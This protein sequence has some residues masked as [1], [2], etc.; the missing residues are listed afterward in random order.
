MPASMPATE[1]PTVAAM[2]WRGACR[3]CPWCGDGRAYF[4][5]WFAKQE[6]C[7]KC[8]LSW[9]RDD[10]GFELGAATVNT[11]VTFGLVIVALAVSVGVT[12]PDVPVPTILIGLLV[13]ALVVPVIVYPVSYTLWQA[14]DLAMRAP[15]DADLGS[16]APPANS[17][18]D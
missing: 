8:G 3:R 13:T 1:G 18:G 14:I 4:T 6:R 5:G 9:R 7:R 17:P 16:S 11:I 15:S 2:L 12:L 10:V